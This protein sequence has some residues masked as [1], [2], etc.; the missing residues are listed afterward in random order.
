MK[1]NANLNGGIISSTRAFT[2]VLLLFLHLPCQSSM[3]RVLFTWSSV[4]E[5]A[6]GKGKKVKSFHSQLSA[7]E[8]GGRAIE[9]K[10][11][12]RAIEGDN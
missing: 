11:G 5:K 7:T 1:T 6:V 2:V 9:E 3:L 12:K 10:N 4:T 8:R